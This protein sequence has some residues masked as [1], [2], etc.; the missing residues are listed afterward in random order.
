[1]HTQTFAVTRIYIFFKLMIQE[2]IEKSIL[3]TTVTSVTF[4]RIN[5]SLLSSQSGY[6]EKTGRC[7]SIV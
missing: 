5:C 4:C 6:K 7:H 2:T 3:N 1:M